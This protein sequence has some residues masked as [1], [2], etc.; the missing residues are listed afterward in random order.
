MVV[1]SG[2]ELY[3]LQ[4]FLGDSSSNDDWLDSL[5]CVVLL[6]GWVVP[7]IGLAFF[8]VF[9]AA[10]ISEKCSRV[11]ALVNA[12]YASEE[13][14]DLNVQYVVRYIVDSNAGFYI[15]GVRLTAFWALKFSYI[16]GLLA[17]TVITQFVLSKS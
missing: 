11:P 7:P 1:L 9:K 4:S 10:A 3:N 8:T 5:P 14:V 2:L 12:W 6:A 13:V 16:F 15:R 17:F